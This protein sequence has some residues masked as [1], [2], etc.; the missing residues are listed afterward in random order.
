[1]DI[2]GLEIISA[3]KS[4]MTPPVIV[5]GITFKTL[6]LNLRLILDMIWAKI[7]I[8]NRSGEV[9]YMKCERGDKEEIFKKLIE[10]F[11]QLPQGWGKDFCRF[12]GFISL[13]GD[14]IDINQTI[15]IVGDVIEALAYSDFA[16][17]LQRKM[18]KTL[19]S[20]SFQP[21]SINADREEVQVIV[22]QADLFWL[23]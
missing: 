23:A 18:E 10:A 8:K 6:S 12:Y 1:M 11:G 9:D 3:Q 17:F 4:A 20:K 15:Q 13:N 2:R 7:D 22:P 5:N 16:T 14:S 19:T 21:Y